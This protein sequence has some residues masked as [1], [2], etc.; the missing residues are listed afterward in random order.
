MIDGILDELK[1]QPKGN[2]NI[3]VQ[4]SKVL[5]RPVKLVAQFSR[6]GDGT[7]KMSQIKWIRGR[8]NLRETIFYYIIIIKDSDEETTAWIMMKHVMTAVYV[9]SAK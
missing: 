9:S 5:F 7:K 1:L 4:G 6:I 3:N 2:N 8:W